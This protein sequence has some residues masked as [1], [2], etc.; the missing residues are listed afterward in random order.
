MLLLLGGVGWGKGT[1]ESNYWQRVERR[2]LFRRP[3]IAHERSKTRCRKRLD[4]VL[5]GL[6]VFMIFLSWK[7][8]P[9]GTT[10]DVILDSSNWSTFPTHK[11]R[12]DPSS[13]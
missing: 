7:G 5:C 10:E 2:H 6:L 13:S 4:V 1:L 11:T 8:R 9:I 12:I 3:Q